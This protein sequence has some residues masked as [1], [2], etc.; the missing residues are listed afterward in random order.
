MTVPTTLSLPPTRQSMTASPATT[1]APS[2][3]PSARR[4]SSVARGSASA[5]RS[6]IGER[7]GRVSDEAQP[8]VEPSDVKQSLHVLGPAYDRKAQ[9]VGVGVP[10]PFEN[11]VDA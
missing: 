7:L 1:P 10:L 5:G 4:W 9:T 3:T 8:V 2:T 6:A 11:E